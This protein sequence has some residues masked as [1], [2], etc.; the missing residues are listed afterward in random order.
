[1]VDGANK[2]AISSYTFSNVQA[3]HTISASFSPV[4]VTSNLA[5]GKAVTASSIEA[6]TLPASYAVDGS[7]TTRWASAYVDPSWIAVDLGSNLSFNRV[8][9][10]WEAAY[11]KAYQIQ[12]SS[13]NATWTPVYTQ[14]AGLGGVETIS[15]GSTTARYVRM[16]GTARGTQWG[17]SLWEFEVYSDAAP[18]T[19]TITATASAGG[20]I[21]P[22]GAVAVNQGAS[23][24]FSIAPA[25]G[26]TIASVLVDGVSQGAPSSYTFS[27][28]QA[29]HTIAA[30]FTPSAVDTNIAPSGTGYLWSK[31]A[32]A[33]ANANRVASAAI[34][35]N[36]LSNSVVV[37]ANGEGG[38]ALWEG[39]GVVWSA[40][41]TIT[42]AKFVN[43]VDDGYGNG[44]FEA[45]C[46]LQFTTDG[47]TW[48]DSGWAISP[49]YPS[50]SAALGKTYTFTGSAS[51]VRGARVVGQT[52][53]NSWSWTVS[54]VQFLGR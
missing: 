16:L 21:S 1:L 26:Y 14:A 11:G 52:G 47:T 28:V 34:N 48:A 6:A 41:K 43:G 35:D 4:V 31:N 23:Q 10:R 19:K 33:T 32:S 46:R 24:T 18:A 9:L 50:S 2:G 30:S 5:L 54:E 29:G 45:G 22:S 51:G 49:A 38:S 20:T 17:Y 44:Y 37:N 25:S 42:S 27:N 12:V 40:A 36:N 13:D 3:A 7:G 53:G 39:A 8:V 15:F